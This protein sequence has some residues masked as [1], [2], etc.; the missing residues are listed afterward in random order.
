MPAVPCRKPRNESSPKT[1]H[2]CDIG[3][4][5]VVLK[6]RIARVDR[7]IHNDYEVL[8]LGEARYATHT[9]YRLSSLLLKMTA[10]AMIFASVGRGVIKR[11]E[12]ELSH[13]RS[14]PEHKCMPSARCSCS[15]RGKRL[16]QPISQSSELVLRLAGKKRCPL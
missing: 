1:Y 2:L 16:M 14:L 7:V 10:V 13:L 11:L 6:W 15:P 5:A 4:R 3:L 12:G 9:Q 8:G